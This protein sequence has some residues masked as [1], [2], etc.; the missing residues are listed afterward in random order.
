[1]GKR[2]KDIA[3]DLYTGDGWVN[4]PAIASLGCWCNII[5]GKRQV[6]K[7][8]GTL[9]Y[10][11]DE[12]RYFL[13]MR[14]T[15]N[16]LQAVA[17]DPDLNPFNALQAV[18]YDVGIRKTGK[19]SYAIGDVEYEDEEDADGNPKWHIKQRRAM[20]LALPSI[21][22]IRGFNGSAFSD[23]V[24]D[25]FIPERI[26][27]KRKAEG[28]ALLNAYVTVCGNRELEGQPPLRMWLLA[29]A[30]DIS[31]PILEQLGCTDLVAKMSRSGRE[32]VMT[33]SGVFVAMPHSD[34]VT[35]K[36][37]QTA[38]MK[39]LAGQGDFYK[40][41]MENQFVYNNLEN[42][43]PRS[44]K[45]MVPLFAYSGLFVYQ[46]DA[47]HYYVC[48]SPHSSHE[49]YGNSAQA[50]TTLQ[51]N[52]PEFRPMICLGQVDFASVP[53]LLKTKNYLDIKD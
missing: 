25:E 31:S 27:A 23:L 13:Y 1:M 33:D 21:A 46:M 14:R 16:E 53:C 29:N 37:R 34:R 12:N 43:R 11:L 9:K 42:V 30:F 22:G 18:G 49:R 5:I 28:E 50:A 10:M 41:A 4:I 17:A 26:V 20:G 19:I 48:E 47:T 44:L 2:N 52:H 6:G 3:L 32:W 36:R 8:F 15:V 38:L 39:H 51:L 40:M 45:G 24:F 7:T 35:D